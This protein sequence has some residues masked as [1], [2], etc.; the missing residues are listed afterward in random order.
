MASR[1]LRL[2]KV[3]N[4]WTKFSFIFYNFLFVGIVIVTVT[5]AVQEKAGVEV[6]VEAVLE[7]EGVLEEVGVAE[8]EEEEE[9]VSRGS[10]Q[11]KG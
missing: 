9:I 4:T 6:M 10:S 7:V 5:E 2:K 11:V 1:F 8:V 3:D